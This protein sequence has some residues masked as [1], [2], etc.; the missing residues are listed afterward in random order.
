LGSD[1]I[2]ID[3]GSLFSCTRAGELVVRAGFVDKHNNGHDQNPL[4][5]HAIRESFGSIMTNSG[6]PDTIVDFWLGHEIG[7]LAEAC[8]SVQLDSLRATYSARK[9]L[10]SISY[11]KVDLDQL[12]KEVKTEVEQEYKGVSQTLASL[13]TE[14]LELRSKVAQLEMNQREMKGKLADLEKMLREMTEE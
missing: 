7:E 3:H 14:N 5:P 12:K 8:K 4:G 9:K 10:L 11:P 13:A 1:T 6:V 2:A